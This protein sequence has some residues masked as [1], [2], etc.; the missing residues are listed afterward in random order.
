MTCNCCAGTAWQVV[1][2]SLPKQAASEIFEQV[3]ERVCSLAAEFPLSCFIMGECLFKCNATWSCVA[4]CISTYVTAHHAMYSIVHHA[5]Q[6]VNRLQDACLG[7]HTPAWAS[8]AQCAL[9]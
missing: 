5:S 7:V 2:L 8:L 1:H 3:Q 9:L 6:S 4:A